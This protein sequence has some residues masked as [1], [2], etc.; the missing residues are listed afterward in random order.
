[1]YKEKVTCTGLY[2][3]CRQLSS[4]AE[5]CLISCPGM[6]LSFLFRSQTPYTYPLSQ[7]GTWPVALPVWT[8]LKISACT[9]SSAEVSSSDHRHESAILAFLLA[10]WRDGRGCS[11]RE[12]CAFIEAKSR[13]Q[14]KRILQ[15][16]EKSSGKT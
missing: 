3:L 2:L 11:R 8:A 16:L 9:G 15:G 5:M 14:R 4:Y 6:G 7:T 12:R 13:A 1:M 10:A